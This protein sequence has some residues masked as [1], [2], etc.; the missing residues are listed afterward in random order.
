[1]AD[2]KGAAGSATGRGSSG[3]SRPRRA[4][5]REHR[6]R[7]AERSREQILAAA[8]EEFA[9]HGFAGA[10]VASIAARAGVNQQLISYYFGGK[11]G[12]YDALR[13]RWIAYEATIA[14]PEVPVDQVIAGYFDAGAADPVAARLLLWQALGDSPGDARIDAQTEDIRQ[15]VA[16][17]RRRQEAGELTK[18]YDAEFIL[19]VC[20]AATMA[21]VSLPHVVRGAYG[22]EPWSAELRNR[23]LP[24]LQRLFAPAPKPEPDG[25]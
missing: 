13:E 16:D 9:A 25:P 14:D 10:R 17:L 2:G 24:Q 6:Q 7:D 3:S 19:I 5:D 23:F 15:V 8:T 21:S 22:A 4:P 20:W 11:Q 12:L 18:D 1:M